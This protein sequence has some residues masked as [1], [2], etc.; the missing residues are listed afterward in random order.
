M[1]KP[2]IRRKMRIL[3]ESHSTEKFEG[4]L[5]DFLTAILLPNSKIIEGTFEDTKNI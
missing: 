5:W 4:E 1:T 3:K 2:T